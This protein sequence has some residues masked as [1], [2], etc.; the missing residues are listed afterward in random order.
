MQAAAG[1]KIF[2]KWC[3]DCHSTPGG[4]GSQALQRKYRGD[5]PD[6]LEQRTDLNP[7]YVRHVVRHGVSFMPSFRKTEISD[8]DLSLVATYLAPSPGRAD[9]VTK[10]P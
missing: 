1:G 10:R 2:G 9:R 5:I 3:G 7:D 4:S 6:I 8:A